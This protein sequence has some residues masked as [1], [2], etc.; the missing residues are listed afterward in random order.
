M[1]EKRLHNKG[2]RAVSVL[3]YLNV[4]LTLICVF[5]LFIFFSPLYGIS[6]A[7]YLS[8][9]P[10]LVGLLTSALLL[11]VR[12]ASVL[13]DATIIKI[14]ERVTLIGFGVC[15]LVL[16][17]I[18]ALRIQPVDVSMLLAIQ[19]L[20]TMASTL[21]GWAIYLVVRFYFGSVNRTGQ[22]EGVTKFQDSNDA[23]SEEALVIAPLIEV[24]EQRGLS[25]RE[26]AALAYTLNGLTSAQVGEYMEI[27]PPTIRTYLQRAYKKL[28]VSSLSEARKLLRD[29][30]EPTLILRHP[31]EEESHNNHGASSMQSLFVFVRFCG[32]GVLLGM[33]FVEAMIPGTFYPSAVFEIPLATPLIVACA[34]LVRR[35]VISDG[36]L[37]NV[38]VFALLSVLCAAL[39]LVTS[40]SVSVLITACTSAV[41]IAAHFYKRIA[42]PRVVLCLSRGIAAGLLLGLHLA[43]FD[44]FVVMHFVPGIVVVDRELRLAS[45]V[46]FFSGFG[47]A[48]VSLLAYGLMAMKPV[49]SV[50]FCMDAHN[51]VISYLVGRGLSELQSQVVWGIFEGK[52]GLEIAQ[53][54]SYSLGSVNVARREAYRQ[55]RVHSAFELRTL[56]QSDVP[57]VSVV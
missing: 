4:L 51:A 34:Y 52:T 35:Q 10:C 25:Q 49:D 30:L 33:F 45:R 29:G 24:L 39:L 54:L 18:C 28:G 21:E 44:I 11:P 27:Q 36:L 1:F 23:D 42:C 19:S 17:G 48:A 6:I 15:A 13:R 8:L 38:P 12:E 57:A 22:T 2:A 43:L 16:C 50:Q 20:C 31:G 55:L 3:G 14:I 32:L 40:V 41:L 9:S 56:I 26:S 7:L 46:F 5:E 37:F 47:L 53:E